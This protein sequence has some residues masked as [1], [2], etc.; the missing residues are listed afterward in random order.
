MG[1]FKFKLVVYFLLLSLLPIAAAFWGFASVAGQSETRAGRRAPA[2]R[3]PRRARGLPGEGGRRAGHRAGARPQPG[4]PGRPPER[5]TSAALVARRCARSPNLY[6]VAAGGGLH[7]GS[8]ARVRGAAAGRRVRA[9]RVRG[10]GHGVVPF[11]TAL[12][13][14]HPRAVGARRRRRARARARRAHRR[15]RHPQVDRRAGARRRADEDRDGVGRALPRARRAAGRRDPGRPL[16]GAQPAVA[17]RRREQCDS[18]NRLLLGL[19]ASLALVALVAYFEG[20]SI[21]RTLRNLAEAAHAI[22]RGS[23]SERVPVRGRDE[24]AAA[25]HGVQRHGE[26]APGQAR[27]ARRRAWAPARR[28][29]P[30]RGGARRVARRRP[31]PPRDRRGRRRGDRRDGREPRGRRRRRRR[32]RRPRR[33]RRAARAA[34]QRGPRELRDA[35]ARRRDFTTSSG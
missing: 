19:L 8:A 17:D 10:D 28:D 24:F 22:A 32:D 4:V 33:G 16:R 13:D 2:G 3:A 34:D 26:P 7:V 20:R 9:R 6:V 29:H 25:R 11:D 1:S 35:H 18:R 31:A 14:A 21:V 5:R 12:V 27:R 23:L 30:L 15:V